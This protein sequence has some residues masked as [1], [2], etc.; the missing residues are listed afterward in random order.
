MGKLLSFE[1]RK[2]FKQK[3]YYI[4][5][6]ICLLM[7]YM[8]LDRFSGGGG[9]YGFAQSLVSAVDISSLT[10]LLGIWAAIFICEDYTVGTIRTVISRGYTR[11]AVFFAKLITLC[12]GTVIMLLLCWLVCGLAGIALFDGSDMDFSISVIFSLA[13]Q[14]MLVLAY[15]CICNAIASAVQK[16]GVAVAVCAVLPVIV[17]ILLAFV[18]ASLYGKG[19]IFTDVLLEEYWINDLISAVG[20][21]EPT[22]ES[23]RL[24][25]NSS[26]IYIIAT[27]VLGWISV[28]KREY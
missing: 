20:N 4:C 28:I 24:A 8:T 25:F 5:T 7:G 26:G 3:S 15:A 27:V 2:L 6:A 11:T 1:F 12:C 9:G 10:M 14:L 22:E 18:D 21:I 13:A 19:G 23:L 17:F 16:T